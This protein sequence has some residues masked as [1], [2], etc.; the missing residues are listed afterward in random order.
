MA[1]YRAFLASKYG[2]HFTQYAELWAWSVEETDAFWSSLWQLFELGPEFS[3]RA[4]TERR[5]PGA[6]WFEGAKLNYADRL[7]AGPSERVAVVALDETGRR[8]S[9]TRGELRRQVACLQR[10]LRARGVSAGDRVAGY[11]PNGVEALVGL[12]ATAS[13]GA[14]WAS[15]PPEFGAASVLDRLQQIDPK[16]LLATTGY[17]YG[18]RDYDRRAVLAELWRGLPRLEATLLVDPQSESASLPLPHGAPASA[19]PYAQALSETEAQEPEFLPVAFEHPLWVLFSSGTTGLPKAIVHSH[20]GMLLE[21]LKVLSLHTDLGPQD[22]FFW[23]STTGWMMWNYLVSALALGTTVVLY[24][25]SPNCP[26]L[27]ALWRLAERER[28]THFG[29]SAPFLHACLKQGLRPGSELDLSALRGVGSTGA[30]LSQDGFRYV[31]ESVASDVHLYSISGGTDV[32]TAFL[33]GCPELPV[34]SGELQCAA[35]GAKVRAYDPSG[36]PVVGRVGELVLEEPMPCMPLRLWNDDSGER[37]FESYFSTFPGVWRHG[38]WVLLTERGGAVIEGR[39]D[40]TLN[41]GGV[42]MGTSELYRVVEADPDVVD[43]LV[44]DTSQAGAQGRLLLFVSLRPGVA[45]DEALQKRLKAGLRSS[46][47][48][49][50]VPDAVVRVD[51]IPT[52]L[53]GKKL[54]VPVKRILAGA[55]PGRSVSLGTLKNPDAL[56]HLLAAAKK[57]LSG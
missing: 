28:V 21:H 56:G 35:L 57:A 54:E 8:R 6:R 39:S 37:Y 36:K 32:C 43:S 25:G 5:M 49:R 2:L 14:I 52:T 26:D 47:S 31:Y 44:V 41:R 53:S 15:C 4:L 22:R 10:A 20:G 9:V 16:V 3:G 12:L 13:L 27:M 19:A 30:P 40:A 7:V 55:D 18:G 23:F 51:E 42:R 50:H 48:P 46:L 24:D 34:Y 11:L 1:R 17:R 29:V 38:D 33:C 45:L